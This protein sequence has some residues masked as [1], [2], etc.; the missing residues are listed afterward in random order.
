[1]KAL[2][3]S[4]QRL[5]GMSALTGDIVVTQNGYGCSFSA[6]SVITYRFD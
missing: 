5:D 2:S 6:V 1:M 3:G 4:R